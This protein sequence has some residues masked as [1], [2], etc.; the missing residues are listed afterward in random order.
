M[1]FHR[2]AAAFQF[3]SVLYEQLHNNLCR[4]VL[5]YSAIMYSPSLILCRYYVCS[6][7]AVALQ[8]REVWVCDHCTAAFH[9]MSL[10]CLPFLPCINLRK[11][12]TFYIRYGG[13]LWPFVRAGQFCIKWILFYSIAQWTKCYLFDCVPLFMHTRFLWA[14]F[15]RQT[16]QLTWPLYANLNLGQE[17]GEFWP[18]KNCLSK[19]TLPFVF[20][21]VFGI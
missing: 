17:G 18:R 15:C 5:M 20:L 9:Q 10:C 6:P 14:I 13:H 16:L 3:V 12:N 21:Y 8:H 11:G 1:T 2:C 4:L 7:K 19:S